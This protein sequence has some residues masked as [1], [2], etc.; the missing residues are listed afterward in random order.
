MKR[1]ALFL[2]LSLLAGCAGRDAP[3]TAAAPAGAECEAAIE[4]WI[5]EK[6]AP[7]Y[8]GEWEWCVPFVRIAATEAADPAD[9]RVWGEFRVFN[10]RLEGETFHFVSGGS[11]PELVHL[12]TDGG[13]LAVVSFDP[14]PDGADFLPGAK[15]IFGRHFA[16]W[17]DMVADDSALEAGR[18]R[19]LAEF[20]ASS[21]LTA[22][23]AQDPGW[24]PVPL[25]VLAPVPS[26]PSPVE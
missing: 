1:I 8:G 19:R 13:T 6:L 22:K 10:Y 2:L 20:A 16:V 5:R 25:P 11:H 24:D 26:V 12:R 14:V 4:E 7:D 18:L 17:R 9:I 3:Q 21:G 15:R 23:Y